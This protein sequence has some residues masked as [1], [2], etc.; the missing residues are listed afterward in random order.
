MARLFRRYGVRVAEASSPSPSPSPSPRHAHPDGADCCC[1]VVQL[2]GASRIPLPAEKPPAIN[3][4][5]GIFS[6]I[7]SGE[8]ARA[9]PV[10]E[11][12]R[13]VWSPARRRILVRPKPDLPAYLKLCS[14]PP[15]DETDTLDRL[16]KFRFGG[17][18]DRSKKTPS[19]AQG[20]KKK[21]PRSTDKTERLRELTEK[22]KGRPGPAPP[23]DHEQRTT[24]VRS[25]S[26]SRVEFSP[27][28]GKYVR[29]PATPVVA[30]G[31]S[32]TPPRKRP[33]AE[34]AGGSTPSVDSAVGSDEGFVGPHKPPGSRSLT[35]PLPRRG[36]RSDEDLP[37]T[38][39]DGN[40]LK[41][42]LY[43][44]A[45][46]ELREVAE[47]GDGSD[48]RPASPG[49]EMCRD[50]GI[51]SAHEDFAQPSV[52]DDAEP[53]PEATA[54]P[55]DREVSSQRP[56][57]PVGGVPEDP[58]WNRDDGVVRRL[59][60]QS[61]EER[62]DESEGEAPRRYSKRPLR[63]PY[64]QMLEAEMKKPEADR[65]LSKLQDLKFLEEYAAPPA[66][67]SPRP[68]ALTTQSLDDSQLKG[69]YGRTQTPT[70]H[71]RASPKRKVS[72]F[73]C[74]Q[75]TTSSPSQLEGYSGPSSGRPE[76][77]AEL[78]RGSSERL[79]VPSPTTGTSLQHSKVRCPSSPFTHH[80]GFETT[81][82][83]WFS[84]SHASIYLFLPL[85]FVCLSLVK[86]W[87]HRWD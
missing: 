15:P 74:H 56:D 3:R 54:T 1:G 70:P 71:P 76:L 35:Y 58:E 14:S 40:G 69:G 80:T 73:V 55:A 46:R 51:C 45:N 21:P 27:M 38:S 8:A 65:I 36:S 79:F 59:Q 86:F 67:E 50:S 28:D 41:S 44:P 66:G 49:A 7:N 39:I 64:G 9:A 43:A 60:C 29:A 57:E 47:E 78:L 30:T 83:S 2:L 33:P 23:T 75:R 68:R 34:E 32:L 77:L 10:C 61:S 4:R 26:F 85:N 48:A 81:P 5:G 53:D 37:F 20:H 12:Q 11:Q 6:R 19:A 18:G 22:L 16:Q 63:G 13:L 84:L 87:F 62:E 31:G 82:L 24:P 52:P 42:L 17:G 25:A 72:A